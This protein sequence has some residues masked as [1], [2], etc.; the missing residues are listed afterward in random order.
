[1][2]GVKGQRQTGLRTVRRLNLALLIDAQDQRV[3]RRPQ[4]QPDHADPLLDEAFV[5]AELERPHALRGQLVGPSDPFDQRLGH[6][7]MFRQAALAPPRGVL[8]RRVQRDLDD[9]PRPV[10]AFSGLAARAGT[11]PKNRTSTTPWPTMPP[12]RFTRAMTC[13]TVSPNSVLA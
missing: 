11:F 7:Q 9:G 12:G 8:R 4:I 10:L 5:A 13:C 3:L 2:L 6:A 1:M